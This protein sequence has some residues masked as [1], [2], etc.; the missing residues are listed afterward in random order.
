MIMIKKILTAFVPMMIC[1]TVFAQNEELLTLNTAEEDMTVSIAGF[2]LKLGPSGK[3]GSHHGL[4]SSVD[5]FTPMNISILTMTGAEDVVPDI[6][7]P[8]S[9][10]MYDDLVSLSLYGRSHRG[11]IFSTGIRLSYFN[12]RLS[13]GLAMTMNET[14]VP[15]FVTG[16]VYDKSKFKL[17]Y[18]GVPVSLGI[19]MGNSFTVSATATF[20]MLVDAR[21]KVKEPVSKTQLDNLNPYRS[22]VEVSMG[23]NDFGIFV[24][25]GLTSIFKESSGIDARTLSIGVRLLK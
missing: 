11:L 5:F 25:Y 19:R 10:S 7:I 8:R 21:N 22:S 12:Y 24:N 23:S 17:T 16:T 3:H 6:R 15:Q 2:D 13:D 9:W 4:S 18:L 1:A 14:G 20:D